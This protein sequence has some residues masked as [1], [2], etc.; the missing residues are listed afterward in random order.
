MGIRLYLSRVRPRRYRQLLAG[1]EPWEIPEG[2]V[3]LEKTWAVL[4]RFLNYEE[5]LANPTWMAQGISGG[6]PFRI[7]EF[8]GPRALSPRHVARVAEALMGAHQVCLILGDL[9]RYHREGR[10]LDER[11]NRTGAYGAPT[12]L[13]AVARTFIQLRD[14][15]RD[16]A[17]ADDAVVI[18]LT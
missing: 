16:A 8:G 17:F 3:N 2:S 7:G 15:Y 10:I 13:D 5:D 1:D 12:S 11:V 14:F 4:Y 9:D 6:E 18:T